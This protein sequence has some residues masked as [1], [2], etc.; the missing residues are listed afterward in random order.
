MA[1]LD[2]KAY[3]QALKARVA[4]LVKACPKVEADMAD[5]EAKHALSTVARRTGETASTIKADKGTFR[6]TNPFLEFGTSKMS[7]Q[8]FYRPAQ[9]VVAEA[10]RSGKYR[11]EF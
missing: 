9:N 8:P 6:A 4:R 1:S 5:D 3:E 11:P 7:A 2:S 10:F